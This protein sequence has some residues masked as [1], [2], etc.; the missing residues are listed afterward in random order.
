MITIKNVTKKYKTQKEDVIALNDI[1]LTLPSKGLI[2]LSGENGCGKS[3][4]L[5]LISTY[6][7]EFEGNIF[8]DNIDIKSNENFIKKDIISYMMQDDLFVKNLNVEENIKLINSNN[9][10]VENQIR[11]FDILSKKNKYAYELSGGQKQRVSMIIS[12]LKKYDI[13]LVD[14]P[15]CS[16][17]EEMEIEVFKILKEIAK[18]KLVILVSHN[19]SLLKENCQMIVYLHDGKL[20]D[21]VLNNFNNIVYNENVITFNNHINFND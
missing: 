17:N 2:G 15:T 14:E 18:E 4:L 9:E 10:L 19:K 8:I 11:S 5:N 7:I 20:T 21:V 12:F 3:T 1:S 16:L 6:D 13:L